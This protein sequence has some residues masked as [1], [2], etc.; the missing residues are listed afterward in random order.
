MFNAECLDFMDPIKFYRK[1]KGPAVALASGWC[2]MR[3]DPDDHVAWVKTSCGMRPIY[4]E[5]CLLAPGELAVK[6]FVKKRTKVQ[7]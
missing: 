7:S 2:V 6:P 1:K 5:R 4:Y 3:I